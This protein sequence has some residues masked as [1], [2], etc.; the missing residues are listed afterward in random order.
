MRPLLVLALVALA[1][2]LSGPAAGDPPAPKKGE[3]PPADPAE[4]GRLIG[5][6][7]S[8]RFADREAAA[9]RLEALG[10]P[11]LDALRRA[12]ASPDAEVRERAGAVVRAI[13]QRLYGERHRFDEHAPHW[14]V[15]VAVAPDGRTALSGGFDR[16]VRLW[17]LEAGKEVRR[18]DGHA[19]Q[20]LAVAF[21]PDGRT[22]LSGSKD[23]TI[24]VWG[25]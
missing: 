12:A 16:A 24:R 11:A 13:Q 21:T 25:C 22:A 18:L 7:G 17:D 10:E 3:E 1:V 6:L 8:D 2:A 20:V 23:R 5:N 4:V 19:D 15:S 14:V 9:R